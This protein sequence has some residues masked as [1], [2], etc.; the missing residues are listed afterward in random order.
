[1]SPVVNEQMSRVCEFNDM[2]VGWWHEKMPLIWVE[3]E[4]TRSAFD[5]AAHSGWE[6]ESLLQDQHKHREKGIA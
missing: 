2:N 3:I 1:M 6:A 5:A 4:T